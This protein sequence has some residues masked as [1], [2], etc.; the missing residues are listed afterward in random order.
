MPL[1]NL[2]HVTTTGY[3]TED[4]M[5]RSLPSGHQICE[6]R[7]ASNRSWKNKI[8]GRWEQ[9][10]DFFPVRVFGSFAPIAH[11]NLRKGSG[12]AIDGRLSSGPS[13]YGDPEHRSEIVVLVENLQFMSNVRADMDTRSGDEKPADWAPVESPL[14]AA[15]PQGR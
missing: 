6:M 12:V 4:P 8:T 14:D 13:L 5:L 10:T 2:N 3:L 1:N 15:A 9:W 7:I 11:R